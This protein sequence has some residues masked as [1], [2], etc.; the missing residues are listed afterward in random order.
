MRKIIE[1]C[2]GFICRN[3]L[4]PESGE[5]YIEQWIVRDFEINCKGNIESKGLFRLFKYTNC[6]ILDEGKLGTPLKE[7][8]ILA[9]FQLWT[10]EC[11]R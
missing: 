1:M 10:T 8:N 4:V 7:W 5:N 11:L 6:D 2:I 3:T 9:D